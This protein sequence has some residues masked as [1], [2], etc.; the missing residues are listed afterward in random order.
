[1]MVE[2]NPGIYLFFAVKTLNSFATAVKWWPYN[3]INLIANVASQK[4]K[5]LIA[6]RIETF[7]HF[8]NLYGS[9]V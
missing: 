2:I 1:M 3:L 7:C 8:L 5:V 9:P 6:R 4:K